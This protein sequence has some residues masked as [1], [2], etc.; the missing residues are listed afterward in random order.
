M[1]PMD[2]ARRLASV[3]MTPAL[4]SFRRL[5]ITEAGALALHAL[6][7]SLPFLVTSALSRAAMMGGREMID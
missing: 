7:S 1:L 4:S 2:V 6:A 5:I 3:G